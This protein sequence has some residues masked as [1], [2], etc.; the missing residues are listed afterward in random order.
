MNT[1]V[2]G[3]L[4]RPILK[5]P[6]DGRKANVTL[7]FSKGRTE[8]PENYR[9]I[10]LTPKPGKSDGVSNSENHFQAYEGHEN[11]WE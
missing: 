10:S 9:L 7:V 2:T 11:D 6:E 1:E 8:D 4:A 3:S 5:V